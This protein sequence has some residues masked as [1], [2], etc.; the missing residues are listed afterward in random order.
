M[1]CFYLILSAR[2]RVGLLLVKKQFLSTSTA[3]VRSRPAELS[4][5]VCSLL[6][7]GNQGEVGEELVAHGNQLTRYFTDKIN[8]IRMELD[9]SK[10]IESGWNWTLTLVYRIST[11]QELWLV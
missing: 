6:R 9:S 7:S 4:Q 11:H 3:S 5:V 8:P 10:M 1:E 2:E